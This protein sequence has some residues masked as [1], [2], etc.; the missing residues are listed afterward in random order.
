M[1]IGCSEKQ[2][3]RVLIQN[4]YVYRVFRKIEQVCTNSKQVCVQGVPEIE[5]ACI[6]SKQVCIQGVP[7]NRTGVFYFKIGMCIVCSEKQNRSVLIQNRYVYSVFRKQ[8]RPVLFQKRCMYV[9]L[10]QQIL[11]SPPREGARNLFQ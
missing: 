7:K 11:S 3:R 8:N 10:K 4:R 2:N 6:N 1:C 9:A 5:Q